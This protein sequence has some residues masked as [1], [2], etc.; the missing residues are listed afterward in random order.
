[1]HRWL[2]Q[3][4]RNRRPSAEEAPPPTD[5]ASHEELLELAR[6]SARAQLRLTAK[7]DQLDAKLQGGL[8]E[9]RAAVR[10]APQPSA[11]WSEVLDA[12]DTIDRVAASPEAAAVPALAEGLRAVG[13][14]LDGA[15][16]RASIERVGASGSPVS[17]K[18]F[19]VVGTDHRPDL[20]VGAVTRVVR[21]AAVSGGRVLREGEVF[22]N[23]R[24][25]S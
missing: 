5:G 11:D 19:R 3:L 2:V 25:G 18:L 8:A 14:K 24:N 10:P 17:G 1:M 16:S 21:A 9:L 20:P 12:L 23:G 13:R 4:L 6:K 22:V 7:L 15:L